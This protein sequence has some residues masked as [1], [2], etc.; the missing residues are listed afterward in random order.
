MLVQKSKVWRAMMTVM[1]YCMLLRTHACEASSFFR[2][3]PA[4]IAE[5]TDN[6]AGNKQE[7]VK[8]AKLS[9]AIPSLNIIVRP[10]RP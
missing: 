3:N 8:R 9:D 5:S 4:S 2:R 1:I 10:F 6:N 7:H